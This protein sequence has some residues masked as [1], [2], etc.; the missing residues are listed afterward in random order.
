MKTFLYIFSAWIVGSLLT[1]GGAWG[2]ATFTPVKS[3]DNKLQAIVQHLSYQLPMGEENA[4]ENFSRKIVVKNFGQIDVKADRAY[5]D[6][7]F[8]YLFN[9]VYDGIAIEYHGNPIVLRYEK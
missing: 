5:K 1:L 3:A 6:E 2:C 7:M 4:I 8:V 9:F